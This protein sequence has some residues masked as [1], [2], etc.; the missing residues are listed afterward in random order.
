MTRAEPRTRPGGSC[1]ME[2]GAR[3]K[4]HRSLSSWRRQEV[5][6]PGAARGAA[7]PHLLV[8]WGECLSRW[9]QLARCSRK[10][11]VD[12][13]SGPILGRLPI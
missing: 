11:R 1:E 13:V 12:L 2:E 10:R 5:V 9:L 3:A 7:C 6:L 8:S 4:E